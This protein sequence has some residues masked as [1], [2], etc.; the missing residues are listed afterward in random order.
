[1]AIS[2]I[3][4][5]REVASQNVDITDTEAH[6]YYYPNAWTNSEVILISVKAQRA[7]DDVWIDA[8]STSNLSSYGIFY[9]TTGNA[10]KFQFKANSTDIKKISFFFMRMI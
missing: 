2:K 3:N 8:L 6:Q 1:M 7:S 9:Y 10:R 5:Y 4:P